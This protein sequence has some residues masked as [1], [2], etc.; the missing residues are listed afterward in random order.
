MLL[1]LA[2]LDLGLG[3]EL[4]RFGSRDPDG[5]STRISGVDIESSKLKEQKDKPEENQKELGRLIG[6]KSCDFV[7]AAFGKEKAKVESMLAKEAEYLVTESNASYIRYVSG[8][9]HVEGYMSTDKKLLQVRQVWY[10]IEDDG[11]I[12]S[13]VEVEIEG[14]K[15]I[16]VWY[17]HYRKSFKHWKIFMLENGV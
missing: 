12:T 16:Q 11:T 3:G 5:I 4:L 2:I 9:L 15:S 13:G 17:I 7:R 8:D 10:V 14:E 6:S 1:V